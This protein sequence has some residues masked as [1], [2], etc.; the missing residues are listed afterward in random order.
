MLR[1]PRLVHSTISALNSGVND[2]RV[3]RFFRSLVSRLDLLSEAVSLVVD[4]R[5]SGVGPVICRTYWA[6]VNDMRRRREESVS[7]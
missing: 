4:V 5:K 2:R 3:R 6:Q 1:S 7:T